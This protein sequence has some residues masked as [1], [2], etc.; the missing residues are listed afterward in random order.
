MLTHNL[1]PIQLNTWVTHS[2]GLRIQYYSDVA[3]KMYGT[4]YVGVPNTDRGYIMYDNVN[5][6]EKFR[7]L[8][9]NVKD[10]TFKYY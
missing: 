1:V 10:F 4:T 8:C 2:T 3:D 9:Q 6:Y 7:S 5:F